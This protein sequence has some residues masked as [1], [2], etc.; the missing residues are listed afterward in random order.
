MKNKLNLLIYFLKK[1]IK[2]RYAGS[3]L[4][5]LWSIFTP[6][7]QIVLFW[8]VFS[9]I[10][11]ARPYANTQMPYIYFLL[12][13]FFFWLALSEGIIRSSNVIIENSEIVKKISFPNIILP[14]TVTISSYLLNVLGFLFFMIAYATTTTF[15]PVIVLVIPVLLLQFLFSL[16]LGMFLAALLPYIRDIGQILG[17]ILQGI[18]FLSPILYGI[19]SIPE[20]ARIIFYL[21]PMTYFASSYHKIILL[22]EPPPLLYICVILIISTV[23]LISGYYTFR[24]LKDGFADV[25]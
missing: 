20:K 18:F 19:E 25:L 21:N 16:G 13:S 1:D 2:T 12:S 10:M 4:G 22:N 11:K 9:G 24:K 23:S 14:I 15:S 5:L 8:F 7:V 3:G 6:L 17:Y